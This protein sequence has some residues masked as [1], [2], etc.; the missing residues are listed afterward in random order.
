VLP[1]ASLVV[2]KFHITRMANES[3]EVV[4]KGLKSSL[5]APQ[6][7]TLKGTGRLEINQIIR[8]LF[9]LMEV[10]LI[11]V[12]QALMR[13][14]KDEVRMD[15]MLRLLE[16]KPELVEPLLKFAESIGR[17]SEARGDTTIGGAIT[18]MKNWPPDSSQS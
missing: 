3:M 2:D 14:G 18:G 10:P 7:R 13:Q 15:S 1:H 11:S 8:I 12:E 5:T 4:R 9:L 17:I 16:S 6:R